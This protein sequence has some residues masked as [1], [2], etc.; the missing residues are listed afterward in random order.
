MYALI[1]LPNVIQNIAGLQMDAEWAPR[2]FSIC[3]GV[4]LAL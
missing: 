3:Y 1:N 2:V 4:M